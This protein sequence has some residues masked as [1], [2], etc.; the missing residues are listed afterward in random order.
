MTGAFICRKLSLTPAKKR[1]VLC[2]DQSRVGQEREALKAQE[3]VAA[4][5]EEARKRRVVVTLDLL[6]R[7]VLRSPSPLCGCMDLH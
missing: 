6:G 2:T 4:E 7:Q 3:R 1:F 5:A